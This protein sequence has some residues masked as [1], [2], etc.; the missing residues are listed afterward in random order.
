MQEKV[1]ATGLQQISLCVRTSAKLKSSA[2]APITTPI[3][4]DESVRRGP[5]EEEAFRSYTGLEQKAGYIEEVPAWTEPVQKY[6]LSGGQMLDLRETLAR[7]RPEAEGGVPGPSTCFKKWFGQT[8]MARRNCPN[9]S[10]AACTVPPSH[11]LCR[12]CRGKKA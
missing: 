12:D 9:G 2:W 8:L 10:W 1:S 3:V 7:V 4:N 6:E 11:E 5:E